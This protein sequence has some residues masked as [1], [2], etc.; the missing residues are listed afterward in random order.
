MHKIVATAFIL[1][2][3]TAFQANACDWNHEAAD[4]PADAVASAEQTAQQAIATPEAAMTDEKSAILAS[5]TSA[6]DKTPSM[7]PIK[8]A[9][10]D[11]PCAGSESAAFEVPMRAEPRRADPTLNR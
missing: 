5:I 3:S 7:K 2:A 10:L 4:A 8:C 1:A 9:V 11:G 6:A